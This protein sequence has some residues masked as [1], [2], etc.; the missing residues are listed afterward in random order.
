MSSAIFGSAAG[1]VSHAFGVSRVVVNL[2]T[3]L[4]ILGF[5]SGPVLW[6]PLSELRGRKWP[7]IVSNLL[8]G[9]FTIGA[10]TAKDLRTLII[11]RFFAG[12][13]GA[14]PLTVVTGFLA[15]IYD[16]TYR[17]VAILLYALTVFGG[18]LTAP[19]IGGLT[20][21][22][23]LSWRWALYI[24]AILSL[25]NGITSL[26]FL[27]ETYA[28]TLLTTKA[29]KIRKATGNWA[30]HAKHEEFEMELSDLVKRYFTRP[31]RLLFTEPIILVI[32]LY[33]AF[34]YGLL[35][36]LLSAYALIFEEKHGMNSAVAGCMFIGIIFGILLALLYILPSTIA[37]GK[38]LAENGNAPVPEW[39][40]R[41]TL[42]GAPVFALGLFW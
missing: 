5:A 31:I 33:H 3:S 16:H 22:N 27:P 8:V 1:R 23:H 36:A 30:V 29:M 28:P 25:T 42:L 9:I 11:C 24:P 26:L 39:R 6:A 21:T 13:C 37:Y 41:P 7:L 12:V 32:S 18:P 4:Y 40:L 35:Y 2:G 17:G 38:K 14:G 19:M 20:I 10:A 34:T 15:D